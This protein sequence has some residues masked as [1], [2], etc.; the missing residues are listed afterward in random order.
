MPLAVRAVAARGAGLPRR[1]EGAGRHA[2]TAAV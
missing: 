2:E 1:V